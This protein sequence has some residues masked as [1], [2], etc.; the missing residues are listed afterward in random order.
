[1]RGTI[2][3]QSCPALKR[4]DGD[5]VFID[6]RDTQGRL[7]CRYDP[8]RHLLEIKRR[9]EPPVVIDLREFQDGGGTRRMESDTIESSA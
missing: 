8:L 5:A 7:M 2:A 6:I 3:Q 1:M 9:H 4:E